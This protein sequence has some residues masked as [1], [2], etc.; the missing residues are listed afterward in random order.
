MATTENVDG[1]VRFL[2]HNLKKKTYNAGDFQSKLTEKYFNV[3]FNEFIS[4][5][6]K[7]I[8]TGKSRGTRLPSEL[9][10]FKHSLFRGEAL[11]MNGALGNHYGQGAASKFPYFSWHFV[12]IYYDTVGERIFIGVEVNSLKAS[13]LLPHYIGENHT[14]RL[15]DENR[16]L[17][18]YYDEDLKHALSHVDELCQ[19]FSSTCD[20]VL[21]SKS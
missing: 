11:F 1:W 13:G 7:N 15:L 3:W 18:V 19:V 5:C 12:S 14:I 21:I 4:Q 17:A 10:S 20:L 2:N 9:D 6:Q 8:T 16:E